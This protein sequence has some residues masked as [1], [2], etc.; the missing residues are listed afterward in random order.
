MT[1]RGP[2]QPLPCCDS[3]TL[4]ATQPAGT[5]PGTSTDPEQGG[6]N[7]TQ[8]FAL[9]RG[10]EKQHRSE[11]RGSSLS[12]AA[13]FLHDCRKANFPPCTSISQRRKPTPQRELLLP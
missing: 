4:P 11:R 10:E 12:S 5:A 6:R 3:V 7:L 8:S 9:L 13:S 1:H 2:F